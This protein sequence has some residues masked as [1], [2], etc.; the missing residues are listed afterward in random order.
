VGVGVAVGVGVGVAV[1]VGVTVGEGV[2]VGVGLAVA[3]GE[4]VGEGVLITSG[5]LF[6]DL[7]IIA[8][9]VNT[10]NIAPPAIHIQS[11]NAWRGDVF[12][13][14]TV[15]SWLGCSSWA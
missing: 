12:G 4:G 13:K 2:A 5:T 3:V 10:N 11:G 1:A 9:I 6:M 8:M 15:W 7:P 14:A